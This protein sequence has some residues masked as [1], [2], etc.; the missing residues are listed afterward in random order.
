MKN[1]VKTKVLLIGGGAAGM[2][3]VLH[4]ENKDVIL[5]ETPKSNSVISPWNIMIKSRKELKEKMLVTGNNMNNRRLLNKFVKYHGNVIA[6]LESYGVMFR[7]SN[8]GVV[9]IYKK[10]GFKIKNILDKKIK[11]KGIKNIKGI[12]ESFIVNKKGHINLI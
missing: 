11:E 12:V 10:S 1:I 9:P 6:D 3:V 2:S 4:L 5:V 7:K 8:I